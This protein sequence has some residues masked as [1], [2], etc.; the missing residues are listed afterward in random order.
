MPGRRAD[1]DLRLERS[2][3]WAADAERRWVRAFRLLLTPE[4][5][6]HG[7]QAQ[8]ERRDEQT[9]GGLRPCF[10]GSAGGAADD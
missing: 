1:D 3:V 10:D 2:W 8:E 6:E 9:G 7:A 4:P 5:A